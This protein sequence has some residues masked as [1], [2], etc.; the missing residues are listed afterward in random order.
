MKKRMFT[1]S[2]KEGCR[3]YLILFTCLILAF[4][5]LASLIQ[6]NFGQVN[7]E[8]VK[9]DARGAVQDADLYT[10]IRTNSNS[11]IPCVVLSHGG[12]CTK[13]VMN[14]FAQE[15]ARRGYAVLN[16]S[17]Y[18]SGLSGQPMYDEDGS[19]IDNMAVTS[20]G[21][22]DAVNY[23]RTLTFVDQT[24]IIIAGHSQGG[25]RCGFT[26]LNDC[27][28]FTLNDMLINF[29]YD[30]FGIAFSEQEIAQ[31]AD[32]LADKY[33]NADQKLFYEARRQ[34]LADYYNTRIKGVVSIGNNDIGIVDALA[35]AQVEVAGHEVTRYLQTNIALLC[36]ERDHNFG[37]LAADV[38]P[39]VYFQSGDTLPVNIWT[40]V[41]GASDELAVQIGDF[42]TSSITD[43]DALKAAIDSRSTRIV[44]P[45]ERATHSTEF[46]E[47][48]TG[49]TV[50]KL[51]EYAQQVVDFNNGPLG[52][53][54]ELPSS[55]IIWMSREFLNFAALLSMIGF[56]VSLFA[57]L[58]K[59]ARYAPVTLEHSSENTIL[60]GKKP[61]VIF[62]LFIV[63]ICSFCAYL[64]NNS[65]KMLSN[66]LVVLLPSN[67]FFPLD[68]TACFVYVYMCWSAILLLVLMA[69]TALINKKKYGKTGLEVLG[70]RLSRRA[71]LRTLGLSLLIFLACYGSMVVI[72]YLFGQDYR[73]WM[74]VFTDMQLIHWAQALR[75]LIFLI[76]AFFVT[77]AAVNM[78]S[79]KNEKFVRSVVIAV[80]I[81][82]AGV[83][84]N[85]LIHIAFM[86]SGSDPAT[87]T[88]KLVSE[89]SITGGM[90]FFVPITILLAKICYKL[91]RSIWTG[92]L[93]CSFLTAW[94]W[95]SAISSTNI[96]MGSTF[97]ERLL[98]F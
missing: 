26:A 96:Y 60:Y 72:R 81:G 24:K 32:A 18:G 61:F 94:M 86:Y 17:S 33:L 84:I 59:A 52:S 36:G 70:I 54:N 35:P 13:D 44:I 45:V 19:G 12:G 2:T 9:F 15:L 41:D 40:K 1:L 66:P 82:T 76:P 50:Q 48:G 14:G 51:V 42:N 38:F 67:K 8:N 69:A 16:V 31:D 64:S 68:K 92:T 27:P 89:G 85:H 21:L 11:S 28:Y 91:T 10:P 23:V 7:I 78:V 55:D 98:G 62:S 65:M 22:W 53:G 47:F 75:Y 87:F 37:L 97:L 34:E 63:V 58:L 80:L 49:S 6:T 88:V 20:Q 71:F 46:F 93:F 39:Q 83:W 73:I 57:L 56:A 43:N 25:Y 30:E 4:S 29:M 77:N 5:F 79:L 3:Y 74:C 95:V 90:L